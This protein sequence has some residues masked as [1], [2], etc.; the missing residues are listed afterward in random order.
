MCIFE[1]FRYSTVSMADGSTLNHQAAVQLGSHNDMVMT[2]FDVASLIL[3]RPAKHV[4]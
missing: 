4:A 2:R 1:E 3:M